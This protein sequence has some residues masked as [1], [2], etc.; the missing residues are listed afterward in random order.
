ME[1]TKN[2]TGQRQRD[3]GWGGSYKDADVGPELG[4][5]ISPQ[6]WPVSSSCGL[7]VCLGIWDPWHPQH[8]AGKASLSAPGCPQ[9]A[10]PL[11]AAA[12][13]W[14]SG[15]WPQTWSCNF[16][17]RLNEAMGLVPSSA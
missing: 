15:T 12:R 9:A 10:W 13:S 16:I 5:A 2:M 6:G 1:I 7:Q 14:G 17:G 11:T 3:E 8:Q 4:T